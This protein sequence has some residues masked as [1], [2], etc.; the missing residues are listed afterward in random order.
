MKLKKN[1]SVKV[2]A[3]KDKGKNGKIFRVYPK[4]QR[5]LVEGINLVSKNQRPTQEN[6][7]GGII[8][9]E[10]PI[11]VSNLMLIDPST[12]K[13]TRVGYSFLS[14]GSKKRISKKSQELL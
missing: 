9:K 13:P 7:K 10:S 3:G 12:S 4:T 8:H 14:D 11:H 2:I 1:D 5:V 6:P